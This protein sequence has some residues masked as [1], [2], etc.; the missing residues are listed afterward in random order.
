M[1]LL[2]VIP[3]IT[4]GGSLPP[5]LAEV[6]I[7]RQLQAD[8]SVTVV[9]LEK[10]VS[11]S[12]LAIAVANGIKVLITPSPT[13]LCKLVQTAELTIVQYWNCPS[14]YQFFRL[15]AHT[16]TPHRLCVSIRVNGFTLPQVIP[17]WVYAA[18]DALI[19]IHPRTLTPGLRST[20]EVLTMP[21]LIQLPHLPEHPPTPDFSTFRLFHAGTLNYF[22]THPKLI[23]LH[24]GLAIPSYCFDVWGSGMDS[25][26][27]QDLAQATYATYRG[28]STNIFSDMAPYHL[29]CNPQTSLS[30]GSFDK[31]MVESQWLGKPVIVLKHSYIAD[32]IQ[33][34]VTGIVANDVYTYRAAIETLAGQPDTYKTLSDSTFSVT[35][36]Q[37]QPEQAVAGLAG[38][39]ERTIRK[40]TAVLHK[41][42][43]P[44]QPSEA[45]LLGLGTWAIQ[46]L[47]SPE[48]LPPAAINYAL[49]CEGGLIHFYNAYP[50]D[51]LLRTLISQLLENEH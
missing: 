17:S 12:M 4:H 31:I 50:N 48:T 10:G 32:H 5:I 6:N 49:R 42:D 30:Y 3:R 21:S 2:Y 20:T 33:H 35:R 16:R 45:A 1:K 28:F 36:S 15:L 38:L 25:V 29:L 19:R 18:A 40:P 23:A 9:T 27:E 47:E 43:L 39:Y 46:V 22:K 7:L 51:P 13:L 24:E 41:N 34:N 8:L 37:Y 11:T 44:E 14:L 26:F